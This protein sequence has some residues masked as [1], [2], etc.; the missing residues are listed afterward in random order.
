MR[1]RDALLRAAAECGGFLSLVEHLAELAKPAEGE[2]EERWRRRCR[3]EAVLMLGIVLDGE[4]T[5]Q[6]RR[7][8]GQMGLLTP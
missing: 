1:R 4:R 8:G 3:R 7:V 5:E 6:F 2:E